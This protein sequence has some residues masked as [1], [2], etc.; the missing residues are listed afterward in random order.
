MKLMFH[1]RFST[2]S[3][4]DSI[5]IVSKSDLKE[6]FYIM[7]GI[8]ELTFHLKKFQKNSYPK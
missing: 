4:A 1:G 3:V 5:I 7:R 6:I 8:H 2:L